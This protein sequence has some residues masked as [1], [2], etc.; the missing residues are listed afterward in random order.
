MVILASSNN[1]ATQ[2]ASKHASSSTKNLSSAFGSSHVLAGNRTTN[3]PHTALNCLHARRQNSKSITRNKLKRLP[4]TSGLF[5]ILIRY[6]RT[7]AHRLALTIL[8]LN[9]LSILLKNL[10]N[11]IR[12]RINT[13]LCD[14]PKHT[15]RISVPVLAHIRLKCL[16]SRAASWIIPRRGKSANSIHLHL[17]VIPRL[18]SRA[19][20]VVAVV[21]PHLCA[22]NKR[23]TCCAVF[24]HINIG[25]GSAAE[26]TTRR[27]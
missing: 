17:R 6:R 12:L 8:P 23:T 25:S 7:G 4:Q 14:T 21:V 18:K 11:N 9:F 3:H 10:L 26:I 1:A 20:N 13:Q 19:V 24:T 5:N 2:R 16:N 15:R 27:T 22:H